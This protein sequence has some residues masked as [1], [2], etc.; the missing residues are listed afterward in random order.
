MSV[1]KYFLFLSMMTVLIGCFNE[2]DEAYQKKRC[3]ATPCLDSLCMHWSYE[4][5]RCGTEAAL[6]KEVERRNNEVRTRI[7]VKNDSLY[8]EYLNVMNRSN[9][10]YDSL[11]KEIDDFVKKQ[12]LYEEKIDNLLNWVRKKNFCDKMEDYFSVVD[13]DKADSVTSKKKIVDKR[14]SFACWM[15]KIFSDQC[16]LNINW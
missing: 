14:K 7:V 8:K 2:Y 10:Q 4:L 11:M 12:K 13:V 9:A 15:K 5:K 6:Q 16:E 1:I 3:E